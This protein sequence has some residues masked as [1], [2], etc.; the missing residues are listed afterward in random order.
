MRYL[1][2]FLLFGVVHSFGQTPNYDDSLITIKGKVVDTSFAVG[3]YNLVVVDKTLGKG[4]FGSYDGKFSITVKKTDTV[5]I[6]VTGY[7]TKYVCF[8]DSSYRKVYDVAFY[9]EAIEYFGKEVVVR[10]LKTLEELKEERASIAKRELP[11]VTAANAITSPITAL[12][13]QFSRREKTKRLV[14]EMEFQDQQDDIVREILRI[15]VHNDIIDL[16]ADDFQRFIRFLNINPEFLK[17]ATDYE[18]ITYI[19]DKY[20]HY[21]KIQEGF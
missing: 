11:K 10:P 5:G 8:K 20:A 21:M 19:Q 2:F 9:L 14:A 15:Y 1:L 3:F 18:L 7:R 17:V 13:V 6:S 16:S 4:I 12:Y